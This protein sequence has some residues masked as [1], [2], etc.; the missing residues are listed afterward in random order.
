MHSYY[1]VIKK[2]D[3]KDGKEKVI[4]TNYTSNYKT[5]PD[6]G[7]GGVNRDDILQSFNSLGEN[8]LKK[9]RKEREDILSKVMEEA[10]LIEKEAYEK[11]YTQGNKNGYE[12][13]H[14]SGYK[15]AYEINIERAK[16]EA[17]SLINEATEVLLNSKDFY[18]KYL[19]D[20]KKEII[21]LSI[22]IAQTVL[23]KELQREN[24]IDEL[25]QEY[26]ESSKESKVF[27]IKC[28]KKHSDS[29]KAH[30]QE[31]KSYYG[32]EEIH[33]IEDENMSEGNAEIHKDK[34]KC[35][36]GIDIGMDKVREALMG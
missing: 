11:G 31:W 10:K 27:L 16:E 7:N 36:V 13:G 25:V 26:I 15:E 4:T 9:A 21:E 1:S 28:N 5:P 12:D 30:I 6:D 2:E 24:G 22:N 14:A 34:G 32:I 35:I 8:I 33:L 20:K 23:K 17:S 18:T 3:L 19:E 29:I